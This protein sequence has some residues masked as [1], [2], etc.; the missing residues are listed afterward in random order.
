MLKHRKCL[1]AFPPSASKSANDCLHMRYVA[2]EMAFEFP[3]PIVLQV[4]NTT[5]EKFHSGTVKR[6]KLKHIDTRQEWVKVLRDKN[7]LKVVHVPTQ[8]NI[9]DIGTKILE[10]GEFLRIRGMIMFY[11]EK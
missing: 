5:A 8:I 2:E 10:P 11:K 3:K 7:I 6:S 9:A 4:D 1:L